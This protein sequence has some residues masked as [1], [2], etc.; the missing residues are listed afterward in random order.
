MW[1]PR[2]LN[3]AGILKL[4]SHWNIIN[5]YVLAAMTLSVSVTEES[6][7]GA[8]QVA[9]YNRS[10]DACYTPAPGNG[11]CSLDWEDQYASASI[12]APKVCEF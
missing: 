6:Q 3:T 9:T 4:A 8:P 1:S 10:F 7:L 12:D 2:L 11:P 5:F